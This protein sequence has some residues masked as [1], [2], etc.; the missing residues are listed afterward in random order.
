VDDPV[1]DSLLGVLDIFR[2]GKQTF[3]DDIKRCQDPM[4]LAGIIR[5]LEDIQRD[6]HRINI[7]ALADLGTLWKQQQQH[8]AVDEAEASQEG[9]A[10][11]PRCLQEPLETPNGSETGVEPSQDTMLPGNHV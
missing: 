11:L 7:Y 2:D 4:V 5:L 8:E 6:A 10:S 3:R 9:R 1:C